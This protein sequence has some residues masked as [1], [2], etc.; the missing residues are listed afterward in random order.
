[1]STSK[2]FL[3]TG[4]FIAFLN[5]KDRH[6]TQASALFNGPRPRWYTSMLV[7]SEAYSWFLHRYGEEAARSFRFFLDSL[8]GLEVFDADAKHHELVCG[9]L[10]RL[11]GTKLTYV[12][13]SS[14][15]LM[16]RHKIKRVWATDHHLGLTGAEVL[17]R[18]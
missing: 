12:D 13:A 4:I 16:T 18:S 8:S 7:R 1:M 14:L 17:P 2:V 11:R 6:H 9:V 3:D 5:R 10:D 15:T